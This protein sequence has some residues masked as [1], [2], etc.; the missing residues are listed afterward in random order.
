MN[1]KSGR[2]IFLSSDLD[3]S[4]MT[5]FFE[6]SGKILAQFGPPPPNYVEFKAPLPTKKSSPSV[7]I[8][9]TKIHLYLKLFVHGQTRERPIS[10]KKK[11]FGCSGNK[12][13]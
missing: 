1:Y 12:H 6:I 8:P 3:G 11:K 13:L 9:A 4:W 2:W 7:Q 10:K 5:F